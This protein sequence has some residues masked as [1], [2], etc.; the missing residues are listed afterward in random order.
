MA[1][2]FRTLRFHN[3]WTAKIPPL[4]SYAYAVFLLQG[5]SFALR[6]PDLLLLLGWMIGAA[7]F[8]HY[9]NDWF[10]LEDDLKAGKENRAAKHHPAF[11]LLLAAALAGVALLPWYWLPRNSL[12]FNLVVAQLIIFLLYSMPPLR[13]KIRGVLGVLADAVYAHVIPGA[14]VVSTLWLS[15]HG[16]FPRLLFGLFLGW[17]GL[18]GI[19]NILNHYVD[20]YEND[21]ASGTVT[22]ATLF[23]ATS[24]KRFVKL[25]L[26]PL[27]IGI[28]CWLMYAAGQPVS[29]GVVFYLVYIVYTFNREVTFMR[30]NMGEYKGPGR[31]DY[32]SGILLNEF[33]E[34]WAPVLLL[35][36][37]ATAE[38]V[39]WAVLA[40]HLALFW[41]VTKSYLL[42]FYHLTGALYLF[43]KKVY[44]FFEGIVRH[45]H[46]SKIKT[47]ANQIRWAA[48]KV[49]HRVYWW[50][51][52]F[53]HRHL[54]E[55]AWKVLRV[56][57]K[58]EFFLWKTFYKPV[59]DLFRKEGAVPEPGD[60]VTE[61]G[62]GK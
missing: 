13:L 45:L 58:V 3:W 46:Y 38:P 21:L 4:L 25:P 60:E 15:K 22:L 19:R 36:L 51:K 40:V 28:L 10:D 9:I 32:L 42:D 20:D 26:V 61:Q 27:E 55:W 29:Y 48:F 6:W 50:S 1:I 14:V 33:Y 5:Q 11:R 31:Y 24:V 41:P 62:H 8:G 43:L 57:Y 34:K 35:I 30:E 23:G 17:Q 12:N 47:W 44:F 49:R 37:L 53:Y 7:A 56:Y 54:V 59:R 2:S 52:K 39:I 16:E 18:I